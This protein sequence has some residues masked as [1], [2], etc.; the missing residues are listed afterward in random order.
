MRYYLCDYIWIH[1]YTIRLNIFFLSLVFFLSNGT[2]HNHL[3]F[4]FL[5]NICYS[6]FYF[7]SM[8]VSHLPRVQ[9]KLVL[10]DGEEW[11]WESFGY[12]GNAVWE[13][14]FN[15]GMIGYPETLTDP[16]YSG[17]ILVCTFPIIWNYGIPDFDVINKFWLRKYF[18]SDSIH[19]RA[20]IVCDYSEKYCHHEA[21]QS[22][23][24]FLIEH[25]IPAIT[26]IDTRALTQKIREWGALLGKIIIDG[27]ADTQEFKDPNTQ[28]LS[29]DVCTPEIQTY[30]SGKKKICLVDMWVKNNI[31]RNL[32]SLDTTIIRVPWYYPFMDGSISFD[33]V[34]LSNGPWD[35]E[36][37]RE[38]IWEVK[39]A[40]IKKIPIFGIC[41]GNQLLSIAAGGKTRKLAYGHRWQNQPCKNL[42]TGKC[43]VTSQNHGFVVEEESLP[44]GIKP[45]FRNLND[46]TNEGIYFSHQ[47]ARSVQFHPES[48]PGPND[49]QSLI[50]DFIDSI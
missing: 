9:A 8:K 31:L 24:A 37:Y 49:S 39:K 44:D 17:Q 25:K 5:N 14:V 46:G 2:N 29:Y 50:V 41:L 38:T 23:S 11:H 3:N 13:V 36:L 32:L 35:P 20:L 1:H 27:I 28:T 42:I 34:F 16:S 33:A 43:I 30:G 19:I 7:F 45:W 4:L 15:T 21:I 40:L 48:S 26:G 22:L 18:E 12:L 10:S 47:N 6:F